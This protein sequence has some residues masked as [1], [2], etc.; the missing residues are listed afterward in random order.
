MKRN[1][2]E[3]LG[4]AITMQID[5]AVLRQQ[6]LRLQLGNHPDLV[7]GDEDFSSVINEAYQALSQPVSRL[8]HILELKGYIAQNRDVSADLLMEAMHW[9]EQL[10]DASNDVDDCDQLADTMHIRIREL[11][12]KAQEH[13][14][15]GELDALYQTYVEMKFI[16]RFI[17]EINDKIEALDET[18]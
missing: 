10:Q 13:L 18:V 8:A 7:D 14:E 2:F 3:T 11:M 6:M 5:T 12:Q 4:I 9:R 17:N 16:D 15:V 1:Y